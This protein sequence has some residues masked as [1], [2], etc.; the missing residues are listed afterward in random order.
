MDGQTSGD[1]GFAEFGSIEQDA[2][3]IMLLSW[4]EFEQ[5]FNQ[6]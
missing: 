5:Q 3:V 6:T 4:D 2:D 1:V